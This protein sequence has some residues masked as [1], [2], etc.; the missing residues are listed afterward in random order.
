M[1][2]LKNYNGVKIEVS[3]NG[4]FHCDI[5]MNLPFGRSEHFF[6]NQLE[7]L[8]GKIDE[9]INSRKDIN[10][11]SIYIA[12]SNSEPEIREIKIESILGNKIFYN[13][14]S[15]S[16]YY[17]RKLVVDEEFLSNP[18]FIE[19]KK[20]IRELDLK[21]VELN[22]IYN[23]LEDLNMRYQSIVKKYL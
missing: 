9:V 2:F 16:G 21:E 23:K 1:V 4:E 8:E 14:G 11:E 6:F 10:Y 22:S 5:I 12:I 7:D 19:L 18:D 20:I 3:E 13:D 15:N 17:S